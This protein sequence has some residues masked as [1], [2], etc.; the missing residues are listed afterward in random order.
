[1][2]IAEKEKYAAAAEDLLDIEK[3]F[4]DGMDGYNALLLEFESVGTAK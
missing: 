2:E 4:S 1:M 3:K